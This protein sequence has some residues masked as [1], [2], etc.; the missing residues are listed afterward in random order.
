MR[1]TIDSWTAM[2]K[3][4]A[5]FCSKH[6]HCKVPVNL[7]EN[8]RLGRWVAVQRHKRKNGRLSPEQIKRLDA[9]GFLWHPG[10]CAW[11]G[12][13]KK[14]K[15]FKK[16]HGHCNV[17]AQFP[18][19]PNLGS[20]VA[21]Q[22]HRHKTG[23]MLP[24]RVRQLES[25]GFSWSVYGAAEEQ[26][27]PAAKPAPQARALPAEQAEERLYNLGRGLYVQYSGK[28]RKPPELLE[29]LAEND[30]SPPYIPLP[31]QPVSFAMGDGFRGRRMVRWQGKGKLNPQIIEYVSENGVLPP[32]S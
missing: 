1:N 17:P 27:K 29:Y 9:L 5:A 28:G 6:R 2:L 32:H 16:K 12:E 3:V 21:N 26:A 30:E 23:K 24:E 18:Q 10:D 25:I 31:T 19:D 14:L 8:Q 22:R 7:S 15:A 4:L 13:F 11:D 20:W